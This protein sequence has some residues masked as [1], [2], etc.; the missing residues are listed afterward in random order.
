MDY[1]VYIEHSAENLQFYL[2]YREYLRRWNAL[3]SHVKAL[4][5]EV[6]ADQSDLPTLTKQKSYTIGDKVRIVRRKVVTES[7][8]ADGKTFYLDEE[9]SEYAASSVLPF[10]DTSTPPTDADISTQ[11]GLN[12]QPCEKLVIAL[13]LP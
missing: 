1:L 7:L 4:S 3:P 9:H 13:L 6:R 8:T 11:A 10:P 5:P 2:C 12:W